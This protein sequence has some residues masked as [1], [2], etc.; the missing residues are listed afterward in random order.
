MHTGTLAHLTGTARPAIA[1]PIQPRSRLLVLRYAGQWYKHC[2]LPRLRGHAPSPL[3][4]R[5]TPGSYRRQPGNR[6]LCG[7]YSALALPQPKGTMVT[8]LAQAP[9][10]REHP[11]KPGPIKPG[12]LPPSRWI[13]LLTHPTADTGWAA[14]RSR[15]VRTVRT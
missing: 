14:R 9:A 12:L 15:R 3:L 6:I 2:A 5:R 4:H 13:Q 1:T 10:L 7:A 11:L 8:A